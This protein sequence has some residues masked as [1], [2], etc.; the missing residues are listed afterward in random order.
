ML[1]IFAAVDFCADLLKE[2]GSVQPGKIDIN[3]LRANLEE[4]EENALYDQSDE[5]DNDEI[6][7]FDDGD[8]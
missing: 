3:A 4:E 6:D 8:F 2:D 7:S 1:E 5:D